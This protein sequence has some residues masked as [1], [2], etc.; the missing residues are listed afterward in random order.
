M[1]PRNRP[2]P[3]GN[4]MERTLINYSQSRNVREYLKGLFSQKE[5]FRQV[6]EGSLEKKTGT[7]E[8]VRRIW[9]RGMDLKL[10]IDGEIFYKRTW[11]GDNRKDRKS[12]RRKLKKYRGKEI[13]VYFE[14]VNSFGAAFSD[15]LF[16]ENTDTPIK[17][18]SVARIEY[19]SEISQ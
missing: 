13:T 17:H 10:T 15:R 7:L 19:N 8:K 9:G 3:Q 5:E 1:N 2:I 18:N 6:D 4:I 14:R 11:R 12:Y 16:L